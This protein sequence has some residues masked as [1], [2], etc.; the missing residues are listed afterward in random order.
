MYHR[1]SPTALRR[2]ADAEDAARRIASMPHE[3]DFRTA[4]GT[5]RMP[6]QFAMLL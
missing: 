3:P 5:A 6:A 2:F 1:V 4:P